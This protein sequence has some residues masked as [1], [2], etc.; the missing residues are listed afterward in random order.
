MWCSLNASGVWLV[1]HVPA[2]VASR[3]A[4]CRALHWEDMR[5]EF[6]LLR[7]HLA[8]VNYN[9]RYNTNRLPW[10]QLASWSCRR[11]RART[12]G[13]PS[14]LWSG[15][16]TSR[17][18]APSAMQA[19]AGW[20]GNRRVAHVWWCSSCGACV[21]EARLNLVSC[22]VPLLL[23]RSLPSAATAGRGAAREWAVTGC[24]CLCLAIAFFC[25]GLNQWQHIAQV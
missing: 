10:A 8:T 15:C 25:R 11:A 23:R 4:G 9:P 6:C 19:G 5:L 2:W 20:E 24:V 21:V 22:S 12:D 18:S 16:A 14:H 13:C 7:H 1:H 17:A 3:P